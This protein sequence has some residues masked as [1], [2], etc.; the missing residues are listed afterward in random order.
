MHRVLPSWQV[1]ELLIDIMHYLCAGVVS[2]Q[3]P[4]ARRLLRCRERRLFLREDVVRVRRG[5][6]L[7]HGHKRD[8]P[9]ARRL[10]RLALREAGLPERAGPLPDLQRG[11]D[12]R[13]HRARRAHPRGGL[14]V[15]VRVE[16]ARDRRGARGRGARCFRCLP[17]CS[18]NSLCLHHL[19]AC[20]SIRAGRLLLDSCIAAEYPRPSGQ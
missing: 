12:Q 1:L 8:D 15:G 16:Q 3:A 20:S 11:R 14:Q 6:V 4:P 10:R 5:R 13:G 19:C 17:S 18:C 9:R 7:H 2:P